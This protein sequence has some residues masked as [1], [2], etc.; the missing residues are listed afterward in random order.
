M[1]IVALL[2]EL[3][4]GLIE[5][6]DDFY[7]NPTD[8]YSFEKATKATTDALAAK[9]LSMA[10]SCMDEKICDSAIRKARYNVQRIRPRTL[11]SSV[12]DLR[13]D[14]RLYREKG[15][16][17]GGYV[18][19][20]PEVL[21]IGKH[22]RFTEEAEVML[23]TEALKTSYAEAAKALPSKQKITKTTVMNKIHSIVD[24]MPMEEPEEIISTD[25]L[26]IEA[27]EDHVAEQHG[28]QVSEEG[29]KSF[30]TKL[31]YIYDNKQDVKGYA[32]RK[33]LVNKFYISGLYPG[34]EGNEQL[35]N[36]VQ[37]YIDS[38]YNQDNLKRIFV[39]GDAAP[40]IKSG[41]DKLDKALFCADKFHLMKYVNL[42]AAQMGKEEKDAFKN[43][44]WHLLYS[45]KK[46]AKARFD[47]YTSNMLLTAKNPD[48]VEDLRKF[49]LGNWAAVR[50]TLRN[51]HTN[52]CSAESHV[53][54]VLSDRLSS[55][56]MGWSQ[57]GADRMSKLRC[58]ERNYGRERIINLVRY[59]RDVQK[60]YRTGTS[61]EVMK[62]FSLREV[63]AEHRNKARGYI[64]AVQATIPGMTAKKT[65]AIR[66]QLDML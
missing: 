18:S 10:L 29:N 58:Y 2:E 30:I 63:T 47:E 50:R 13:F 8:L 36:K 61:Y 40:W 41:A 4:N 27:D 38:N 3:V 5:A 17:T 12:G 16:K 11:V 7:S 52:G 44:L 49:A 25:Y 42:A 53:S 64:E 20:L 9:F 48:R 32:D 24:E 33:E 46:K 62:Q 43:E 55:R 28:E 37:S 54:H 31:V 35:W 1:E 21:G 6:E 14:C 15:V 22:E 56:P 51:K 19:I 45:K 23:Y 59:S 65:A 66:T 39:C 57:I 60:G 34:S 26:Y